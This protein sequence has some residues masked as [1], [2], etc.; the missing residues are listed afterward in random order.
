[1]ASI[2]FASDLRSTNE[3]QRAF[4]YAPLATNR[5]VDSKVIW[6]LNLDLSHSKWYIHSSD[7]HKGNYPYGEPDCGRKRFDI[8]E[9][10]NRCCTE[11][12]IIDY[13]D[14]DY[15]YK[16]T[17]GSWNDGW[18]T[19]YHSYWIFYFSNTI[20][21]EAFG[22]AFADIVRAQPEERRADYAWVEKYPI[23]KGRY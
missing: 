7:L 8:K 19:V 11:D 13:L 5:Y 17:N 10:I 16:S 15:S 6:E 1:M 14:L 22:F 20:E 12:V 23:Q 3:R 18:R 9:Y 4:W 2:I 21:K